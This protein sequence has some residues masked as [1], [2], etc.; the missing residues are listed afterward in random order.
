MSKPVIRI[1]NAQLL[2]SWSYNLPK[3]TECTICR[4][5]LNLSSLKYQDKGI[6]SYVITGICGHSFHKECI[7]K[8]FNSPKKYSC[9]FCFELINLSNENIF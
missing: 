6:E 3:N 9:P 5:N 7:Y 2:T 8:W 1:N 4:Q